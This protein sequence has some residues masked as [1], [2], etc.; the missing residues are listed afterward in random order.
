MISLIGRSVVSAF[1]VFA[2]A[3]FFPGGGFLR[4][5]LFV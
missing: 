1:S 4:L 2:L 3:L 5:G